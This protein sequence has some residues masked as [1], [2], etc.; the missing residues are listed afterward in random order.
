M[1]D[2][3]HVALEVAYY[4]IWWKGTDSEVTVSKLLIMDLCYA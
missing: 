3:Y 2:N 4:Y 1:F